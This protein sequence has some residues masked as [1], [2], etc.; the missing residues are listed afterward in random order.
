MQR[1]AIIGSTGSGKSTLARELSGRLSLP[2]TELDSLYWLPDWRERDPADFRA[3]VDAATDAPRWVIDGGYSEVRDLVWG[4]A[5]AIVWLDYSFSRTFLQLARRTTRRNLL[6]EPCCGDNRESL[7]RSLSSDSIIMWLFKT[8]GR[9]R[10]M[11]PVAMAQY[12]AGKTL[13]V[14]RSPRETRAWLVQLTDSNSSVNE[15]A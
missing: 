2:H 8:Y 7:R 12:G 6:K 14:L 11:L 10:R 5:T 15:L 3:L 9:N 13:K 1:I 4:R